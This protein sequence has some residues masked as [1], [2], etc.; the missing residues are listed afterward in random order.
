M[1]SINNN[2]RIPIDTIHITITIRII[3]WTTLERVIPM[4]IINEKRNPRPT[5]E[6]HRH[7]EEI[8]N[9]IQPVY[10]MNK[11]IIITI[12]EE[13]IGMIHGTGSFVYLFIQFGTVDFF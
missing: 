6:N 1:L 7:I 5:I 13:T 8:L 2:V 3:E 4:T 11:R 12:D 10:M 9:S